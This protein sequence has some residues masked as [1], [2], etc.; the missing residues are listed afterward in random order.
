M[1]AADARTQQA[2]RPEGPAFLLLDCMVRLS[3]SFGRPLSAAEI[4][5]AAGT[6]RIG[7]EA[8]LRAALRLGLKAKRLAAESSALADL[9]PPFVV[10]GPGGTAQ[11]AL[12]REDGRL[13][14]WD[15]Q[16]DSERQ[17]TIEETLAIAQELLVLRPR[18]ARPGGAAPSC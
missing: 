1:S 9:P 4:R 12:G 16:S 17:A 18:P 10:I 2:T 6:D 8:A 15:P 3:R 13:T 7:V 5:A 14:L 11:L